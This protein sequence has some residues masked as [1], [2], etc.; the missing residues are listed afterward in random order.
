MHTNV[1]PGEGRP[2]PMYR[3]KVGHALTAEDRARGNPQHSYILGAD[4]DTKA[5]TRLLKLTCSTHS[6]KNNWMDSLAQHT[7]LHNQPEWIGQTTT[8][9][10]AL[11]FLSG[12]DLALKIAVADL[13]KQETVDVRKYMELAHTSFQ[14]AADSATLSGPP[15]RYAISALKAASENTLMASMPFPDPG[16]ALG[17]R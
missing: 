1:Q 2:Q 11:A 4:T 14:H 13:G 16:P 10:Q 8:A 3:I 12:D 17:T 6:V 15:L 7:T 5:M 9:L